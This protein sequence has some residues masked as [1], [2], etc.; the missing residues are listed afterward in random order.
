MRF[1][2]SKNIRAGRNLEIR[3]PPLL[4]SWN[5]KPRKDKGLVRGHSA[6]RA[7]SG[8][9]PV[10]TQREASQR[11]GTMYEAHI[12]LFITWSL[13]DKEWK[14][15]DL[16]C[17]ESC[18][19]KVIT[20]SICTVSFPRLLN[21]YQCLYQSLYQI[22]LLKLIT[23]SILL[24]DLFVSVP[25]HTFPCQLIHVYISTLWFLTDA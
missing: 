18:H 21:F 4:D 10:S 19:F 1:I 12:L 15:N 22:N 14:L 24:C 2:K 17:L 9:F 3:P 20:T 16:K 13:R 8:W 6:R 23:L 5:R 7:Q 11:K 25:Q